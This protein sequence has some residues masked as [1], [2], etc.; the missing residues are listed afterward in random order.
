MDFNKPVIKLFLSVLVAGLVL[1][2]GGTAIR[3][4]IAFDLYLP[5]SELIIKNWYSNEIQIATVRLYANLALYTS[6]GYFLTLISGIYFAFKFRGNYKKHGWM[7][8]SVIFFILSSLYELLTLYY[9]L[10]LNLAFASG[11]KLNFND[12]VIKHYFV[13]RFTKLAIPSALAF[14][15]MMTCVI[16]LIWRPLDKTKKAEQVK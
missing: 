14:F 4:A 3:A 7:L 12:D 8:M 1:W 9:D 10:K 2:L 13:I 11:I 16:M 15:S 6:I 5:G